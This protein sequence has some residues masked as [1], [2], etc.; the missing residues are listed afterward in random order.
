MTQQNDLRKCF[1]A[2]GRG[3]TGPSPEC[4]PAR[5]GRGRASIAVARNTLRCIFPPAE[6]RGAS[7]AHQPPAGAGAARHRV[8]PPTFRLLRGRG[9]DFGYLLPLRGAKNKKHLLKVMNDQGKNAKPQRPPWGLRINF[10]FPLIRTKPGTSALEGPAGPQGATREPSC[11][12]APRAPAGSRHPAAGCDPEK[13]TAGCAAS[14]RPQGFSC[15][16]EGLTANAN[17]N[18]N[19]AAAA[20]GRALPSSGRIRGWVCASTPGYGQVGAA[21]ILGHPTAWGRGGHGASVPRSRLHFLGLRFTNPL[22]FR[23]GES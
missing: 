15:S 3:E 23:R 21:P 9:R 4:K 22:Y 7:A 12:A 18:A 16:P 10:H 2:T 19:A 17:A 11:L 5:L 8:L 20:P 14:R 1:T 6:P 13:R